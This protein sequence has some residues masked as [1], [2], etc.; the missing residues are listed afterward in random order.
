[1][2]EQEI[3]KDI[4]EN[5]LGVAPRVT[6]ED[7]DAQIASEYYFTASEGVFGAEKNPFEDRPKSGHVIGD[8]PLAL[9]TFCVLVLK[10]GFTITGQSACASPENFNA[11]LGRKIARDNARAKIWQLEGYA[12]RER[13]MPRAAS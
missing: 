5:G 11:Q 9:L 13:L 6:P 10:N 2:N 7:V 8:Y 4:R 1:M 3:E 12:L